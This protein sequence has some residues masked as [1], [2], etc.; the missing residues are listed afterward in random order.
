MADTRT[1]GEEY[2]AAVLDAGRKR[3]EFVMTQH[4]MRNAEQAWEVAKEREKRAFDALC[5]ARR[6]A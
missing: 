4:E 6:D 3:L 2:E 5:R 1:L